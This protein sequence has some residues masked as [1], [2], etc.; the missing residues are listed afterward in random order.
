M[1]IVRYTKDTSDIVPDSS[2][3]NHVRVMGECDYG[4]VIQYIEWL[5]KVRCTNIVIEEY[6]LV[7]SISYD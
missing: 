3:V 1:Y 2:A 5:R 6:L 4:D 7:R